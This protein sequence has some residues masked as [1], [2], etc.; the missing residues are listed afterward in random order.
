MSCPLQEAGHRVWCSLPTQ[1]V[2]RRLGF[3]WRFPSTG[4]WTPWSWM[5]AL[6]LHSPRLGLSW[7]APRCWKFGWLQ[8]R[9]GFVCRLSWL[10]SLGVTQVGSSS[11]QARCVELANWEPPTGILTCPWSKHALGTRLPLC[12]NTNSPKKM[13]E[14]KR[15]CNNTRLSD[16][17]PEN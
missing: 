3:G 4:P 11:P 15:N 8:I 7:R 17:K 16:Q 1:T 9:M 2:W 14:T 6:L 5:S 10:N 12:R 13:S